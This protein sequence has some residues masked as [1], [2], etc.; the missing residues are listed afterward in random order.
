MDIKTEA[1]R[2]GNKLDLLHTWTQASNNNQ[3]RPIHPR[4]STH[5]D[6]LSL[7]NT[8]TR[9]SSANKKWWKVFET[10]LKRTDELL[11]HAGLYSMHLLWAEVCKI[12]PEFVHRLRSVSVVSCCAQ[13]HIWDYQMSCSKCPFQQISLKLA[14]SPRRNTTL[15]SQI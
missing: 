5:E 10:C 9:P 2:H 4:E 3:Q 11:L 8:Q 13:R 14:A 6:H 15:V 12:Q 7:N 1:H